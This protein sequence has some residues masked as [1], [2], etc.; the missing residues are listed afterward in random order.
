MSCLGALSMMAVLFDGAS[1]AAAVDAA[2]GPTFDHAGLARDVVAQYVRPRS[3]VFANAATAL[4]AS[5][6]GLCEKPGRDGLEALRAAF[7]AAAVAY[8]D[9]E[10]LRIGPTRDQNRQERLLLYPDPRGLV[11]RQ[12]EKVFADQPQD[13]TD[14]KQLAGKSVALQGF[15]ALEFVL[16]DDAAASLGAADGSGAFRCAYARAITGN[17][18]SIAGAISGE[19]ARDDGFVKLM[20]EPSQDNPAYMN[21]GEV[22]LEIVGALVNALEQVRDN[23]IA[24][25]MGLRELGKAETAPIFALSKFTLPYLAANIDGLIDLYVDGGLERR[26]AEEDDAIAKLIASE[27][28]TSRDLIASIKAPFDV[29]LE[30]DAMRRKLVSVGFPMKNARALTATLAAQA[31]GLSIGFNAGDGD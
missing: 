26:L 28:R 31:T 4:A 7:K 6:A 10:F 1:T 23:R 27:M 20:R 21:G 16:F 30:T 9:I 5:A 2:K 14:A 17:I 19:W 13:V 15:S 29:A 11:R 22:T 18:A 8:A 3:E 12:V 25:P 24:A